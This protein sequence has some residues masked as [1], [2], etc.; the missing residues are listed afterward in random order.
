M[1][2]ESTVNYIKN[3]SARFDTTGWNAVGSTLT[4]TL[5]RA[6]F[7]IASFKVVTNGLALY[8]GTFY[9]VSTLSGIS[10]NITVSAYLRGTGSVRIRLIDNPFGQERAS[11]P[12]TLRADR[13]TR[14]EVTGFSTGS[15]DL[16]L[17][18]ETDAVKAITFY[19]DGAQM[20]RKPYS[21]TYCDGDQ[22][23]CRWDVMAHSSNSIREAYT[24]VG[25]RWVELAGDERPEKDLYVTVVGGMGLPPITNNTQ[26]FADAPGSYYQN[27]KVLARPVTFTFHAKHEELDPNRVVTLAALHELRQMLIDLIKSDKTRGGQEFLLEYTDGDTPLYLKARY[28][29]GLEGDWDVRNEWINSF[30]VR[31]LAV[32][33]FFFEDNQQ[34]SAL[35]FQESP[36]ANYIL[37]RMDSNWQTMNYGLG[38]QVSN[39]ALGRFGEVIAVGNFVLANFNASAINPNI[40]ANFIA[41]WDGEKWNRYGSGA[42]NTISGV[43]VAPNGYV[44]VAGNFTSIGG[45]AANRVAY[46]NGS[47]WNAMGSGL[48]AFG[49][50]IAVAPNGDVYVV[51]D[52]DLAGGVAAH[53]IARWDGSWHSV[54]SEGGLNAPAETIAIEPDGSALYVGGGF[55]DVY[56]VATSNMLNVAKF[57][58][59]E[60]A[61]EAMGSGLNEI[62]ESLKISP[63]G[64]LYAGGVF[65]ASGSASINRVAYWNGSTWSALGDGISGFITGSSSY[66]NWIDIRDNGEVIAVGN[67][68]TA[69]DV[70]AV[71]VAVWNG[72]TWTNLDI[73][74]AAEIIAVLY[75]RDG[76]IY[77]G[78]NSPVRAGGQTL[79]SNT[80]SAEVSPSVYIRGPG[81]LK[82]LENYTT[83]KRAYFDLSILD[84]EEVMIDFGRCRVDSNVRGD[85][86]YTIKPGSD[87]RAFTLLPRDNK[88][89]AFMVNDVGALMTMSYIPK[90]WSADATARGEEL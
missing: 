15:N 30:P 68:T 34:V 29:G 60:G 52:F 85:L 78:A 84:G 61:W 81:T 24:R 40:F 5:D 63:S 22:E 90:H 36:G 3:P 56:G 37:S 64:V 39:L 72:S 28:D 33:P 47:A 19:V 87:F 71:G 48:D 45:V 58:I 43:A 65:T 9:R 12:V 88:I 13:W 50:K 86:T 75:D 2:P 80:G 27:T 89:I 46:W 66:V 70:D 10:D 62:V 6:R 41:Y 17:Y 67:F 25:G 20:E 11:L 82:F 51:G 74:V 26:S 77:L 35:D 42:N 49:D 53:N 57:N 44:Y 31:F 54:G 7:G 83:R 69:G 16:R 76:N 79:V 32:S 21:T 4:R 18:V 55:S 38:N 8:E 59:L 23:G 73:T 1:V 14:V